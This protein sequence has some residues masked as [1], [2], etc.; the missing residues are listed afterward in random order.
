M[1]TPPVFGKLIRL[2]S[3]FGTFERSFFVEKSQ[4][5]F[6]ERSSI[7]KIC[8]WIMWPSKRTSPS[9]TLHQSPKAID[10]AFCFFPRWWIHG[11]TLYMVYIYICIYELTHESLWW[12][13]YMGL[14]YLPPWL[15]LFFHG[16]YIYKSL[17][18]P[19]TDP[20]WEHDPVPESRPT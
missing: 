2:N 13:V 14:V 1:Q 17:R 8:S 7:G 9:W 20:S 18:S 5:F 6:A 11:R 3:V 10:D 12:I 15:W 16:K 4:P 19:I